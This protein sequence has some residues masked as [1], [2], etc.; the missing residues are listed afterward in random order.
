MIF[1]WHYI[2]PMLRNFFTLLILSSVHTWRSR[3]ICRNA[4]WRLKSVSMKF[5]GLL[6]YNRYRNPHN[7]IYFPY[8]S[9][10]PLS[11]FRVA[12]KTKTYWTTGSLEACR[13]LQ[14]VALGRRQRPKSCLQ[15]TYMEMLPGSIRERWWCSQFSWR[16]PFESI[17]PSDFSSEGA[18][19]CEMGWFLH[20]RSCVCG[21]SVE[22]CVSIL[23]NF[24]T[25]H[26]YFVVL[27]SGHRTKLLLEK[28]TL[29]TLLFASEHRV[30]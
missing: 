6:V 19:M 9:N 15:R 25:W 8:K 3:T 21:S 10:V 4:T 16:R 23:A 18:R 26:R 28:N 20:C 2:L 24:A 1:L 29:K 5:N 17:T 7:F 12:C 30:H 27:A 11:N 22:L 14:P 13:A